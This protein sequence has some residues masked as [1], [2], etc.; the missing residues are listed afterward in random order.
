MAEFLI[1]KGARINDQNKDSK[2]A[3]EILIKKDVNIKKKFKHTTSVSQI[4]L[5]KSALKEIYWPVK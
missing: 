3:L 1:S 5:E 2:I 4:N